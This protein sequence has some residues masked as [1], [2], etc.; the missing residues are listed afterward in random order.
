M[1]LRQV[2]PD[3]PRVRIVTNFRLH[4]DEIRV[5]T[6]ATGPEP[7]IHRLPPASADLHHRGY[8]RPIS[9]DTP[10]PGT[11]DYATVEPSCYDYKKEF[12][13]LQYYDWE[14]SWRPL[15]DLG[16]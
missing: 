2:P 9:N 8:S 11:F 5:D 14:E 1:D 6:L 15:E 7:V 4:W 13:A 10:V 3:D 16:A 12:S